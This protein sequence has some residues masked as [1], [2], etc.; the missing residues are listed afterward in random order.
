MYIL[1]SDLKRLEKEAIPAA[2]RAC[3]EKAPQET[4]NVAPEILAMSEAMS[5]KR[6]A[7]ALEDGLTTM[8]ADN[9]V[10][11][12]ADVVAVRAV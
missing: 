1:G 2:L 11:G 8:T 6:I 9:R 5:L 10:L 4:I 7:D 3:A 12:L